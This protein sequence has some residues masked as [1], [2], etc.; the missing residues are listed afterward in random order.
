MDKTSH[1]RALHPNWCDIGIIAPAMLTTQ[2]SSVYHMMISRSEN[3][4]FFVQDETE[5]HSPNRAYSS[6]LF[7]FGE[8][9]TGGAI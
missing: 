6:S 8:R 2:S 4:N 9:R 5:T 3:E 7:D 1:R